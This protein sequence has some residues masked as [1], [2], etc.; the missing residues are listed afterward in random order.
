MLVDDAALK[1]GADIEVLRGAASAG[2][3]MR[4]KGSGGY[5]LRLSALLS[6]LSEPACENPAGG[7]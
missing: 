6:G 7:P 4:Y 5:P 3:G 1:P 2:P